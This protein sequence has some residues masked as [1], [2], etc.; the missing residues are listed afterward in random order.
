MCCELY[1]CEVRSVG[2]GVGNERTTNHDG[3]LGS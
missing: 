2:M 3:Y 1:E